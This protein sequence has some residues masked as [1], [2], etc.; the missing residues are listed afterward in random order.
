MKTKLFILGLV[1]AALMACS[2]KNEPENA[3]QPY[4][5]GQTITIK[6]TMAAP[7]EGSDSS[8]ARRITGTRSGQDDEIPFVWEFDPEENMLIKDLETNATSTLTIKGASGANAEFEG[9][10]PDGW[11]EGHPF[12]AICGPTEEEMSKPA[13]TIYKAEDKETT[14]E[15]GE[16]RFVSKEYTAIPETI[17][18]TAVWSAMAINIEIAPRL[19]TG[20]AIK[21]YR[22]QMTQLDVFE[23]DG[24]TLLYHYDA[25]YFAG[26]VNSTAGAVFHPLF[27]VKNG[28]YEKFIFKAYFTLL[29]GFDKRDDQVMCKFSGNPGSDSYKSHVAFDETDPDH[30]IIVTYKYPE[31]LTLKPNEFLN[32]AIAI[33]DPEVV[34]VK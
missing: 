20:T 9:M 28:D 18:L 16:M 13:T 24:S 23:S 22:L 3:K 29:K 33:V 19:V 2:S 14:I 6:C 11:E 32:S 1:A 7:N 12:I 25:E 17:E 30:K 5:K 27:V 15:R 10:M 34:E 8:V 26:T 21:Y 4:I 31:T